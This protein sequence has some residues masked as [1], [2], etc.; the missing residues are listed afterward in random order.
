M[1]RK[2][3]DPIHDLL[4][5]DPGEFS[6]MNHYK[7]PINSDN[8]VLTIAESRPALIPWRGI[9]PALS[10]DI[11][12]RLYKFI[13]ESSPAVRGLWDHFRELSLEKD[14]QLRWHRRR[15]QLLF[16]RAEHQEKTE[17]LKEFF[18]AL[19][20]EKVYQSTLRRKEMFEGVRNKSW[21]DSLEFTRLHREHFESDLLRKQ[22][23]T[24]E[25]WRS[26]YQYEL[27]VPNEKK[28]LT[29]EKEK[30]FQDHFATVEFKRDYYLARKLKA[31]LFIDSVIQAVD[32]AN[33]QL[34]QTRSVK[35]IG[36]IL[37]SLESKWACLTKEFAEIANLNIPHIDNNSTMKDKVDVDYSARADGLPRVLQEEHPHSS[38]IVSRL[39]GMEG[40]YVCEKPD[41]AL[42]ERSRE[43]LVRGYDRFLH[44]NN[45]A[46]APARS[47]FTTVPNRNT[48]FQ[49]KLAFDTDNVAERM[50]GLATYDHLANQANFPHQFG[51]ALL[52]TYSFDVPR[53]QNETPL[54][55]DLLNRD[56]RKDLKVLEAPALDRDAQNNVASYQK[57]QA[58]LLAAHDY[59]QQQLLQPP[60]PQPEPQRDTDIQ[61][62]KETIEAIT[63]V[64]ESKKVDES[65]S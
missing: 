19:L 64:L 16:E 51:E 8:E 10:L 1:V 42:R 3:V 9:H 21:L 34:F 11:D 45:I 30:S 50:A 2:K 58:A 26:P 4:T 53:A 49:L 23:I 60:P 54:E 59:T 24:D 56:N 33:G 14:I 17:L 6:S 15:I 38:G 39:T 31:K 52:G 40:V 63:P 62:Q 65:G 7:Q 29:L 36:L 37:H 61:K 13:S 20:F 46:R 32:V 18:T 35:Q 57:K 27:T 12:G 25:L 44:T 55:I 48:A 28:L 41:L 22:K 43:Y 47:E 5:I